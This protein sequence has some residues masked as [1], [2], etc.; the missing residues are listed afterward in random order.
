MNK[1]ALITGC[2]SGF[3]K[4]AAELFLEKGWNVVATMR[5]PKDLFGDSDRVL[6]TRLDVT[7]PQSITSAIEAGIERFGGIDVI[8]N[9]AGIGMMSAVEATPDDRIRE[10]FDTNVFGLMAVTKA[11]IPH[12]RER[13]SGTIINVTSSVAIAPVPMLAVYSAS[14]TAVEGFSESLVYELSPFGI[15][16]RI[17]EPGRAPSTEFAANAGE[18]M[19]GLIPE[20]Y[21]GLAAKV[22]ETFSDESAPMTTEKDVAEKVL[23]AA[24]DTSSRLWYPAGAD[25]ESFAAL[26]S[27]HGAEEFLERKREIYGFGPN[28]ASAGKA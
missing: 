12:M 1:T 23:E 13:G 11:I 18:R 7:D 6:T 2:S 25:S 4:A 14:K 28:A 17:V 27:A 20:A 8:V 16:V 22:F 15:N 24:T 5:T 10:L 21:Q 26:R 19:A 3:G 9:N